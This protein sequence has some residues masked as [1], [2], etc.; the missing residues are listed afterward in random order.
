[1]PSKILDPF[2]MGQMRWLCQRIWPIKREF[3]GRL[4]PSN[5]HCVSRVNNDRTF[6][7]KS[8]KFGPKRAIIGVS[9]HGAGIPQA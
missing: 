4:A 6:I 1:M 3:R 2:L 5:P 7:E 9:C 8:L